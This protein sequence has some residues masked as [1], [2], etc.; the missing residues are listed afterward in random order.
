MSSVTVK[1]NS[2]KQSAPSVTER[3]EQE[4]TSTIKSAY[5]INHSVDWCDKQTW[6]WPKDEK[7]LLTSFG[8]CHHIEQFL[9]HIPEKRVALQAGGACGVYPKYLAQIFEV[10]YT[11]EPN[12]ELFLCLIENAD[13]LN[14]VKM[15]CAL[16]NR[17]KMVQMVTAPQY[18]DVNRGAYWTRDGGY[19]PALMI[20]DLDLP[21]LDAIILDIEGTECHALYGAQDSI[22]KHQP[23]I[24]VEDKAVCR[25]KHEI[26]EDWIESFCDAFEYR[27][28][29]QIGRDVV[30]IHE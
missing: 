8:D 23:L 17:H 26:P 4:S 1:V 12:Y 14:I 3:S 7:G 9:E 25:D 18:K 30:L 15:P 19:I 13:D 29:D 10:V 21:Y 5:G 16:S 20:D 24:I 27:K 2:P 28:V 11:F 6:I 22:R